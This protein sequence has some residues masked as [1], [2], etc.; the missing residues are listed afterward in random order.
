M[1]MAIL[2]F[3]F[4]AIFIAIASADTDT[5]LSRADVAVR[6]ADDTNDIAAGNQ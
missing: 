2:M 6:P 5:I 4:F 1:R 3:A